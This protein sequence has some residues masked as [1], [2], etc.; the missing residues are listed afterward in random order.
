M[1]IKV[2]QDRVDLSINPSNNAIPICK[3]IVYQEESDKVEYRV[4][5]Q[6]VPGPIYTGC[7]YKYPDGDNVTI[8]LN[9]VLS[10]QLRNHISYTDGEYEMD[11]Y[12]KKF[13]VQNIATGKGAIIYS[14]NA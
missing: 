7:A 12:F 6:E 4:V 8:E 1:R 3:P 10:N 2:I 14:Y 13:G 11:G 9:E 5:D